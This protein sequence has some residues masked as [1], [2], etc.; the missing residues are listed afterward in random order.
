MSRS[1]LRAFVAAGA[2]AVVLVPAARP[3]SAEPVYFHLDVA[4][5]QRGGS[6]SRSS[7]H[8]RVLSELLDSLRL[9]VTG[10]DPYGW[11]DTRTSARLSRRS[12]L[13][14]ISAIHAKARARGLTLPSSAAGPPAIIQDSTDPIGFDVAHP[15]NGPTD[16]LP[17]IP[18]LGSNE[19]DES[20]Q[21]PELVHGG[22][23]ESLPSFD[24]GYG[25]HDEVEN[26]PAGE[27][28]HSVPEPASLSLV[29]VGGAGVM[30]LR[31][32]KGQKPEDRR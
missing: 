7:R 9:G 1:H 10:P 22:G 12:A 14:W 15:G 30:L 4:E 3:A 6:E 18:D 23:D 28:L 13:G 27:S 24:E 16:Q 19:S 11:F 17:S 31:R 2:F 32:R 29:L 21:L 8:S 20:G 25:V 26:E 5:S